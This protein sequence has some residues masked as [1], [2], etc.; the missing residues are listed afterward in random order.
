[1]Q[2][3]EEALQLFPGD[4]GA[5]ELK[6]SIIRKADNFK[7]IK[8]LEEKMNSEEFKSDKYLHIQAMVLVV[9]TFLE[10]KKHINTEK[11]R[12]NIANFNY[13]ALLMALTEH[14]DAKLYFFKAG[15]LDLV[16]LIIQKELYNPD[17]KEGHYNLFSFLQVILEDDDMYLYETKENGIIRVV[18]K[19][20]AKLSEKA[21]K[22]TGIKFREDEEELNDK[23]NS[24]PDLAKTKKVA[25]E[26]AD[27]VVYR[28]MEQLLEL[29]TC[30][31]MNAKVRLYMR[32]KHHLLVPIFGHITNGLSTKI[33]EEYELYSSVLIIFAN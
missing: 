10:L 32:D 9:D 11:M 13:N 33:D 24:N 8:A 23:E 19:N 3:V 2:D 17:F 20:L 7:D 25:D 15:G 5:L 30:C 16:K 1:M 21:F 28:T 27:S 22:N 6:E 26:P 12:D 14:K 4:K 29:L 31:S 18:I